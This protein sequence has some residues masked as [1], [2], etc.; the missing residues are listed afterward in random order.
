MASSFLLRTLLGVLL[1]ALSAQVSLHL[2]WQA[3]QIPITGQTLGVLVVAYVLG[4]PWGWLAVLVYLLAGGMGLPFFADGGSGWDSFSKGSAGFLYGFVLGA[5][6]LTGWRK[7]AGGRHWGS[8]LLGMS[9]GTAA[10]MA[11]GLAYLAQR[12]GWE[13]ALVYGFYPFWPGAI[14]KI[15]LG[16]TLIWGLHRTAIG[17]KILG[18]D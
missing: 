6:I 7:R 15:I 14:V 9:L 13:K 17:A 5:A 3:L 2:D 16:A 12:Y 10:I 18:E 11:L 1:I 8:A 4:A